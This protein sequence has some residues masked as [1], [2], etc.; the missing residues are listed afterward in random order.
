MLTNA[1]TAKDYPECIKDLPGRRIDPQAYIDGLDQII[2]NLPAGSAIFYRAVRALRKVCGIYGLLPYSHIIS[3]GL[4]LV[5]SG[6]AKRPFASGG[7]SDVWKAMNSGRPYAIKQLR[8]YEVDNIEKVKKRYCKEVIICRRIRHENVLSVE[9][10]APGLFEFCIVSKWMD[11]GNI[12]SYLK[13]YPGVNRMDLLIGITRGLHHL[14][15][16]E[17][18]HGDLKGPN[19]LIDRRGTPLL[20][21]FGLSSITRNALSVNASTPHSG[22]T[23]RWSA[24]ELLEVYVGRSKKSQSST[25]KSDVYALSMVIVELYSGKI[26]FPDRPDP[27]VIIMVSKGDRPPK[28]ASADVLGLTPAVWGLTKKCWHKKAAKRPGTSEILDHL[29]GRTA[30]SSPS[31]IKRVKGLFGY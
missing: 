30:G 28:P 27:T 5:N 12:L 23:I 17:L 24:P 22:G 9:G 11:N 26:P 1:F 31:L 4:T 8:T 25:T 18:V 14:H 16:N 15:S 10:V 19:I 29:E 20:A 2:D 21:D 6:Q 3:R 13:S 7:F